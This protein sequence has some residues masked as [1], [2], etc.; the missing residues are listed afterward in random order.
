MRD[1]LTALTT[2]AARGDGAFTL[3]FPDGW[4][5]GRGAFG[6]LVVATLIRT[7]EAALDR[8]WPLRS[9]TAEICGPVVPGPVELRVETL[10]AGTGATTAAV[11]L[12][13]DGVVQAHAV[14]ILGKARAADLGSTP[15]GPAPP[16]WRDIPVAPIGPPFG[17]VFAPHFEF[18]SMGPLP[19]TGALVARTSGWIRPRRPG[20]ARDA[21]YLAA[22]I[23]AWWPCILNRMTE[24]RPAATVA[25]TMQVTGD[26]R[27]L[28]P[29]AP[30]YYEA[31]S[32]A[33]FEGHA[34][35]L[36][37]LRGTDGRLVA[38]NQQTFTIIR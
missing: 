23:D 28:D 27:G 38:M 34:V 33:L 36:R 15:P 3:D 37:S 35:E 16:P 20:P 26:L 1:D 8:P 9:I 7:A 31:D 12:V 10:R 13:Q 29:D 17:P 5:Q 25:F 30:L 19:F 14:V 22:C 11:R 2:P 32:P 21:A 4:Q 24:P 18:R 6:G